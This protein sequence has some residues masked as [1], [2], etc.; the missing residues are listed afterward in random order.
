MW[1]VNTNTRF[2]KPLAQTWGEWRS[3]RPKLALRTFLSTSRCYQTVIQLQP[4]HWKAVLNIAVAEIGLGRLE[5][6]QHTLKEAL[7]MSGELIS[8]SPIPHTSRGGRHLCWLQR[9]RIR[10]LHEP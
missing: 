4:Q 3:K 10:Y 2:G 7:Q 1:V 6:A 5:E 8:P 9:V